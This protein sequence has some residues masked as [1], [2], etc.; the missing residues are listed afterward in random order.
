MARPFGVALLIAGVDEKGPQL[1]QTDP[2]GTF[3]E[4]KARAIG[5]G[6]ETAMTYI[7]ESYHSNM[8]LQEAEKLVLQVLKNVMEERINAENVEVAVVKS[9][10]KL[11]ETRPQSY[12]NAILGQL[13]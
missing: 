2:S 4:W 6:G 3:L 13:A 7:K 5:S 10:T 1:Y 12:I 9:D 11:L 8:T